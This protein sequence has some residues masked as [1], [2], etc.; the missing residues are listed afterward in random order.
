MRHP[1]IVRP[2]RAV[3]VALAAITLVL[4]GCGA[5]DEPVGDAGRDRPARAAQS[6]RGADADRAFLVAMVPHHQSAVQMAGVARRRARSRE[7]QALAQEIVGAQRAEIVRMR[8]IHQRLFAE[9]LRPDPAAHGRLGLSA[10]RAGMTHGHDDT[11]ELERA[12]QFDLAFVDMMAPHHA[13]AVRMAQAVLA[14]GR[15]REVR[16]LARSIV[17]DQRREIAQMAAFR[18]RADGDAP[19]QAPA[20]QDEHAAHGG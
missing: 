10:E 3:A 9:P 12:D 20:E 8:R 4:T 1:Q 6:A 15:D 7:I 14:S 2:G 17:A 16:K 13:G 11:A 18:E 5:D 19:R